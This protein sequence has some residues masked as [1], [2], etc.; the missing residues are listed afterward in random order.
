MPIAD[1][2]EMLTQAGEAL[3]ITDGERAFA[4]AAFCRVARR[5]REEVM[6]DPGLADA[7][8]PGGRAATGAAPRADDGKADASWR[9]RTNLGQ[10][11]GARLRVVVEAVRVRILPEKEAVLA[12]VRPDAEAAG[13]TVPLMRQAL[14]HII[15]EAGLTIARRVEL[16]RGLARIAHSAT[17][18]D[19]LDRYAE[20]GLGEIQEIRHDGPTLVFT[21]R[22][23]IE[24]RAGRSTT[25]DLT[26]GYLRGAAEVLWP[27]AIVDGAETSCSSRG[28]PEC[29]FQ[30]RIGPPAGSADPRS[31]V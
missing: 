13:S 9:F 26:L 12:L 7:V 21:A 3:V 15:D 10:P 27:D 24:H 29:R 8:M 14:K 25:C 4:N 6:R 1:V 28:D 17:L 20:M 23:T 18:A 30:L 22:H 31:E 11:D 16:G 19:C 2:A 5:T